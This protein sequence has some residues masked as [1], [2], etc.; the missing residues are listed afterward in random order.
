M[1]KSR[2][3]GFVVQMNST[4]ERRTQRSFPIPAVDAVTDPTDLDKQILRE[5]SIAR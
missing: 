3:L 1:R 2:G 5:G 4:P